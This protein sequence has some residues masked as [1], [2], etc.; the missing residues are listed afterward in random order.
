MGGD[1]GGAN[2]SHTLAVRIG[3]VGLP[4]VKVVE[5]IMVHPFF[6]GMEDDQMWLY[7]CP[8]NGGLEDPRLKPPARDLARIGCGRVLIFLAEKDHLRGV[9]GSYYEDL[10][11]SGWVGRVEVVDH[12]GEE[13]V[14]HLMK[15]DCEKAIDLVNKFATFINEE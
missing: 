15:P 14:F 1:S 13:H 5:V 2:I 9:G 10:K 6:G 11:N 8:T 3:S 4:G 7:M 12:E